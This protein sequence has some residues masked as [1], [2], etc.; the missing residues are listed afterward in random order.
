MAPYT[1]VVLSGELYQ[2]PGKPYTYIKGTPK[3][4][5]QGSNIWLKNP[6][7]WLGEIIEDYEIF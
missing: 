7:A 3:Y 2:I 6:T 5:R 4:E 1:L